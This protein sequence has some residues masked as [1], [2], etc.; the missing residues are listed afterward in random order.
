MFRGGKEVTSV[1]TE[2]RWKSSEK[3]G[4]EEERKKKL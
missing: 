2:R 4:V 1:E 3:T